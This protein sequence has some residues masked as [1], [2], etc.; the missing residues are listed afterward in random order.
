MGKCP[1]NNLLPD[2]FLL[3]IFTNFLSETL[4]ILMV[5]FMALIIVNFFIFSLT[6]IAKKWTMRPYKFLYD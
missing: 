3:Q 2:V 5:D 4:F 6:E 1:E